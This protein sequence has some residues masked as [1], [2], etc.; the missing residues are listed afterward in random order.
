MN[1]YHVRMTLISGTLLDGY[2]CLGLSKS[3]AVLDR[4]TGKSWPYQVIHRAV[5]AGKCW[6][7]AY[8]QPAVT[9]PAGKAHIARCVV[10]SIED[11]GKN[12]FPELRNPDE[13]QPLCRVCHEPR[14]RAENGWHACFN[15]GPD[16]APVAA[17]PVAKDTDLTR[18]FSLPL[19]DAA[20]VA[21]W[22][23]EIIE[24]GVPER[25]APVFSRLEKKLLSLLKL[26]GYEPFRRR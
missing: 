22:V 2:A 16:A 21:M 25:D 19:Y 4:M 7:Q 12:P 18:P 6:A 17:P 13:P 26:A 20:I 3:V 24:K 9:S 5:K 1:Y 14:L 15:C 8:E 10:V 11:A 23:P